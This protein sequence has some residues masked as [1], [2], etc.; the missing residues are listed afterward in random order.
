MNFPTCSIRIFE[1]I[2]TR[3]GGILIFVEVGEIHR[4]MDDVL[5]ITIGTSIQILLKGDRIHMSHP[6]KLGSPSGHLLRKSGGNVN[7]V[8]EH[9]ST[10]FWTFRVMHYLCQIKF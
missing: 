5:R 4:W 1:K 3:G 2:F 6:G 7:W 10:R 8:S 9:V